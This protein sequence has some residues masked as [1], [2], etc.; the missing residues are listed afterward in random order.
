MPDGLSSLNLTR[1]LR[2]QGDT[3]PIVVY[4]SDD[5]LEPLARAAGVTA[6]LVKGASL[7]ELRVLL[8]TW[9][10]TLPHATVPRAD[11]HDGRDAND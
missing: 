10:G 1:L 4:T 5:A 2:A 9:L 8:T 11:I 7:G 6:F 3:I